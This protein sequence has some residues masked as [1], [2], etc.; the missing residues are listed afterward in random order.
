[1]ATEITETLINQTGIS[2]ENQTASTL[3]FYD[4][5][6]NIIKRTHTAMGRSISKKVTPTVLASTINGKINTNN[7]ASTH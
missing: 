1:M 7:R 3:S 2:I 5:V 6:D 4:K